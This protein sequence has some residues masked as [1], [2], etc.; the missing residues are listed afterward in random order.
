MAAWTDTRIVLVR[1]IHQAN[2]G[3]VARAMANMGLHRLIVVAPQTDPF[4]PDARKMSARAD[5]LLLGARVVD[6]LEDALAGAVLTVGTS[7]RAGMLR[8]QSQLSPRALGASVRTAPGP[9]AIV[10]GPEDQG[11]TNEDLLRCDA[12]VRI[13]TSPDYPSLNLAQSVGII[14]YELLSAQLPAAD[15]ERP[16]KGMRPDTDRGDPADGA[17]LAEMIER[18]RRPLARIGYLDPQKP[19]KL[20]HALR[21]IAGRAGLTRQD[22]QILI[23]LAQQIDRFADEVDQSATR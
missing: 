18:F 10:F 1:P 7:C 9:C 2:I 21:G 20:L 19:D 22:A 8:T 15:A 14:A 12:T 5:Q 6:R 11:L 17:L 16:T 4:G 23:G 3:S 13:P